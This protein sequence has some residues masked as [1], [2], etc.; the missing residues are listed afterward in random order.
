MFALRRLRE[1]HA[2]LSRRYAEV[3]TERDEALKAADTERFNVI[4][5]AGQ[6]TEARDE[7]DALREKLARSEQ[8]R[9]NLKGLLAHHRDTGYLGRLRQA[10]ARL[11]RALRA[12][13]SYRAELAAQRIV[14]AHLTEQLFDAIGYQPT[15]RALLAAACPAPAVTAGEVAAP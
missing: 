7:T 10:H 14:M 13:A 8:G 9:R 5:L 3:V 1:D 11:H 6:A 4:R 2:N 12:C 15:D